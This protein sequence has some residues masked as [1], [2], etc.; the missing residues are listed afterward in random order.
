MQ[1]AW[2]TIGALAMARS[3]W[4]VMCHRSRFSGTAERISGRS[5]VRALATNSGKS[6][7]GARTYLICRRSGRKPGPGAETSTSA[8][9]LSGRAAA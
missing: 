2:K 1:Q 7:Q 5:F 9:T 6:S 8:V 3:C 4:R